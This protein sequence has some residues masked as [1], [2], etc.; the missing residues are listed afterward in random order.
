LIGTPHRPLL[1]ELAPFA[2]MPATISTARRGHAVLARRD[3]T[4]ARE[5]APP[6]SFL[7]AMPAGGSCGRPRRHDTPAYGLLDGVGQPAAPPGPA[8]QLAVS[9]RAVE[10]FWNRRWNPATIGTARTPKTPSSRARSR[11]SRRRAPETVV[12][13][14]ST[15]LHLPLPGSGRPGNRATQRPAAAA[16]AVARESP[17][18][19][20]S[21]RC[22]TLPIGIGAD[23]TCEE[24]PKHR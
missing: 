15:R 4:S 21:R 7:G 9:S 10:T 11:P 18:R 5:P 23:R 1:G 14:R 22:A 3:R 2:A 6:A 24:L 12:F 17:G 8:M 20:P 13:S 19:E 16:E